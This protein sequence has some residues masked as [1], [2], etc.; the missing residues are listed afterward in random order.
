[1]AAATATKVGENV[2]YRVNGSKL[3]IEVDL[4]HNADVTAPEP[5][6]KMIRVASSGGF[7]QVAGSE[8]RVSLNAGRYPER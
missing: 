5:G 7:F 4:E 8:V 3:V 2:S 6:K 1:M